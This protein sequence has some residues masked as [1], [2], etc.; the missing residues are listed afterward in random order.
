MSSCCQTT[1]LNRIWTLYM[2]SLEGWDRQVQAT[3]QILCPSHRFSS[4]AVFQRS[5]SHQINLL[6]IIKLCIF[7]F[8]YSFYFM[9]G[10][11][12]ALY[13]P[14]LLVFISSERRK[15]RSCPKT[16]SLAPTALLYWY[17]HACDM[18][19]LTVVV[20]INYVSNTRH[21]AIMLLLRKSLLS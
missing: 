3:K 9:L 10:A 4:A 1:I 14:P 13:F 16:A 17:L 6:T 19:V 11:L 2:Q 12:L 8:G 18:F 20:C 7:R 5:K 15:Q 21:F